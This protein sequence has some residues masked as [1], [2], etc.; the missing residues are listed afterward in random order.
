MDKNVVSI[1]DFYL[2]AKVN[3][4]VCPLDWLAEFYKQHAGKLVMLDKNLLSY[5]LNESHCD[6]ITETAHDGFQQKFTIVWKATKDYPETKIV[7]SSYGKDKI[8]KD[9]EEYLVESDTNY[10]V[11]EELYAEDIIVKGT[12]YAQNMKDD[13]QIIFLVSQNLQNS[14][15]VNL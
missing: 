8:E 4:G 13:R 6:E 9:E 12:K 5:L 1:D 3:K 14:A 7:V 2:K 11:I 15:N 10:Y